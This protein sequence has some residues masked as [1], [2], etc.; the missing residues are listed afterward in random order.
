MALYGIIDVGSNS[1]KLVVYTEDKHKALKKIENIKVQAHLCDHLEAGYLTATGIEKL[2]HT[3]L[4]FQSVLQAY[5]LDSLICVGTAVIRQAVNRE[6]VLQDV[7]K[8][9]GIRIKVMTGKEEA[10]YG[11]LAVIHSSSIRNAIIVDAGGGST[12]VS[13]M[14]NGQL[15]DTYSFPFGVR[16]ILKWIIDGQMTP[17]QLRLHL[18]KQFSC[19]SWIQDTGLPLFCLGGSA[20][21]VA[22]IM[23]HH[24]NEKLNRTHEYEIQAAE[25]FDLSEEISQ[26]KEEELTQI[27]GL[28]KKRADT[29][30]PAVELFISLIKITQSSSLIHGRRGMREGLVFERL[31]E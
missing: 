11:Y 9:T 25:L 20:H 15:A 26:L 6:Q 16:T 1:I 28:S 21:Q 12:E 27:P 3:L 14:K 30:I 18:I 8:Q 23:S 10:Y 4:S 5:H 24:R 29:I 19:I 7:F 13:L 31:Y 17:L 22:R 2:I